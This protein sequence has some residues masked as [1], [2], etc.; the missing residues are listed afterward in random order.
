M[1]I[2]TYLGDS[3]YAEMDGDTIKLTT[4]NGYGPSNTIYLTDHVCFALASFAD[5]YWGKGAT[6]GEAA[7]VPASEGVKNT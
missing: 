5:K 4:D 1:T 2:K 6:S 7:C 3:V